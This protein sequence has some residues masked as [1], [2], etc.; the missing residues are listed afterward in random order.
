MLEQIVTTPVKRST[1]GL[2]KPGTARGELQHSGIKN[3]LCHSSSWVLVARF[4]ATLAVR[5]EELWLKCSAGTRISNF[6]LL[7]HT[8][9][10]VRPKQG[11]QCKLN[12]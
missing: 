5:W 1:A 2:P 3:H 8:N 6:M 7:A 10:T 12:P 9:T 11:G 4:S